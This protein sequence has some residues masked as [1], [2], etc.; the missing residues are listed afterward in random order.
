MH[1]ETKEDDSSVKIEQ[2]T[3]YRDDTLNSNKMHTSYATCEIESHYKNL[4]DCNTFSQYKLGSSYFGY[5]QNI[6]RML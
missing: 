5:I 1:T 6:T 4:E 2:Y 3:N